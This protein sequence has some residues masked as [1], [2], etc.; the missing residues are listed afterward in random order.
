MPEWDVNA[1][2]SAS[3][4]SCSE[5]AEYFVTA[6][7]WSPLARTG[8]L[9]EVRGASFLPGR[10]PIGWGLQ[11]DPEIVRSSRGQRASCCPPCLVRCLQ[12]NVD[13]NC[14]GFYQSM[15]LGSFCTQTLIDNQF[16]YQVRDVPE[17]VDVCPSLAAEPVP[18][19]HQVSRGE[20]VY[21]GGR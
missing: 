13:N 7:I 5:C 18:L 1:R 19:P 21:H 9:L 17:D 16:S 20:H 6:G 14:V 2:K 4:C 10:C 8:Y 11:D 15:Y 3:P 12:V